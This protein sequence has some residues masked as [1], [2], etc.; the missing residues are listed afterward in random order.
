MQKS[1][2]WWKISLMKVW[3][4]KS[5]I[6]VLLMR[7]W[8]KLKAREWRSKIKMKGQQNMKYEGTGNI[9]KMKGQQIINF[10]KF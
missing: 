2:D 1:Y 7:K 10:I 9:K 8:D 6:M 3:L 4:K 5:E